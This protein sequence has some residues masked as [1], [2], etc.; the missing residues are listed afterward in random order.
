MSPL[1]HRSALVLG[2][3]LLACIKHG[4]APGGVP[5]R[6]SAGPPPAAA[7]PPAAGYGTAKFGEVP[8][9]P[10]IAPGGVRALA[11]QGDAAKVAISY[12]P[13]EGQPF[14]EA[15]RAEVKQ[16]TPNPWDLQ[17]LVTTSQPIHRGDVLLATFFFRTEATRQESGEGQTELVFELAH[18]PWTKSVS[19]PARASRHW[20]QIRVP[21]IAAMDYPA[22]DAK[23]N[24]R[25]GFEPETVDIG[26][27]TVESFGRALALGALP[28]TRIGYRGSEPDAPWR[29]AAAE[30]IEKIRKADLTVLA[31][32][33]T[34]QH[35]VNAEVHL[36]QTR[37]AF[38]FGTCVA[39]NLL[40]GPAAGRYQQA[41]TELFNI[42]TL[43]NSLKWAPLAGDWGP[44]FTIDAAK[45][46]IAWLRDHGLEVRGH[47]LVWPGWKNLPKALRAHEGDPAY[48]DRAV[49]D[50]IREVMTAVRGTV[51]HWDVVN[52][53]FDN[54]DLLDILGPDAM[55][56]WFRTARATD[57]LPKLF[58]NDYAIL[59]GGGGDTPHRAHYEKTI[60]F[61]L[62]R[63]APLD[64][65]G[66]QGH[67]GS[68]LTAPEDM[69]AILD[70]FAKLG[71]PIWITEYDVD[72]PD[73]ELAGAF[74][75]DFYT[76]MFSHPS[77][78]G[79]VMWGFWDSAHWKHNAPIYRADWTEK[80][81][82]AAVRELVQ[83]SWRTDVNGKTD[84]EG[85]YAARAFLGEYDVEVAFAG[86]RKVVKTT[87]RPGG[88]RITVVMG[89]R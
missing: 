82:G 70:R 54:H 68:S 29:K 14:A 11:L 40:T 72:I 87:L 44:G 67:F 9:V 31:M 51:V 56:G 52:E 18:D 55:A 46:G 79:I 76:T 61:L 49:E 7:A 58:I 34:G 85:K 4:T 60:K 88:A 15:V 22:G 80:P 74:T 86:K 71:K 23:L 59:S 64:G 78:G 20:Q 33:A 37:Q 25:L 81:A 10:V 6:A 47:V 38:G 57:P 48:L 42:A 41:V 73:E 12:L 16:A 50:R 13:V 53:P 5:T 21:F 43:E 32:D 36:H 62:E 77:V 83:R 8:G 39:P 63:K 28:V 30:R 89:P 17:L 19:F 75:R 24:F 84:A 3:A 2:L 65:I 1:P 69:L 66:M 35:L 45:A 27:L 26:G